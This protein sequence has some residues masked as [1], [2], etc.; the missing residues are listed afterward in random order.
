VTRLIFQACSISLSITHSNRRADRAPACDQYNP[1]YED[2]FSTRQLH[3]SGCQQIAW[4]YRSKRLTFRKSLAIR[5]A[6]LHCP[7]GTGVCVAN[8]AGDFLSICKT[9][10]VYISYLYCRF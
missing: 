7:F 3:A 10:L 9:G 2:R 6:R 1:S 4:S 5:F 8:R